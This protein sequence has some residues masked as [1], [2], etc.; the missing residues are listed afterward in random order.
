MVGIDLATSS[1]ANVLSILRG[2]P[3]V[4]AAAEGPK[5]L[6]FHQGESVREV[7]VGDSTAEV[8]G[9]IELIDNNPLVCAQ[10]ASI[11]I[12]A[13]TMASIAL[14]PVLLAGIAVRPPI[15]QLNI[16]AAGSDLLATLHRIAP[17]DQLRLITPTEDATVVAFVEGG[18]FGKGVL[19]QGLI[20]AQAVVDVPNTYGLAEVLSMFD[21]RFGRCFYVRR[22][23][24]T[25]YFKPDTLVGKPF[26]SY[27]A[28]TSKGSSETRVLIEVAADPNGKPGAAGLIH[29]MNVMAG[30]EE[31]MGLSG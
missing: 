5:L 2:H 6:E 25:G 17:I 10:S 20:A 29:A 18:L 24:G 26:A 4:T 11:P 7:R 14:G 27:R 13:G 30:L 12:P 23:T 19:A 1:D 8:F 3:G 28:G 22:D 21:E 9:L 31:S 16:P 15:L